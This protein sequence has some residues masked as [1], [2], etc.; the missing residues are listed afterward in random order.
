[1]NPPSTTCA[2]IDISRRCAQAQSQLA[3][4]RRPRD[5][6]A[7]GAGKKDDSTAQIDRLTPS[8]RGHS[9]H[10]LPCIS[11]HPAHPD[12]SATH[13][14]VE[15]R[16]LRI[17]DVLIR[18]GR[19]KVARVDAIALDAPLGPLVRH[20][21]G[22]LQHAAL[23]AGVGRDVAAAG[24]GVDGGDVDDFARPAVGEQLLRELLA[25]D[26][27]GFEVDV[28]D[29]VDVGVGEVD[30][31]GAALDAG[32]VLACGRESVTD[33]FGEDGPWKLWRALK[34]IEANDGRNVRRTS[35]ISATTPSFHIC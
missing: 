33:G 10:H 30:G 19:A 28:D 20:G 22:D 7:R 9:A 11:T 15:I 1:M 8:L 14:V 23:A 29:E 18:H 13:I 12:L 2:I 3:Y 25:R 6:V 16:I 5:V 4:H 17:R 34:V 21:L 35:T 32:A 26:E 24:E 27:H 31:L